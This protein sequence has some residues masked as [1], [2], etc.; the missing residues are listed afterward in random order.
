MASKR[1]YYEILGVPKGA[2]DDELKKAYRKLAKKYHPDVNKENPKEAEDK[3]KEVNEAYEI[4]SDSQKRAQYDQ[5]GHAGVDPNGFGAGGFEGFGDINFGDIGDIFDTFFGFGG[6]SRKKSGPQ[7]GT[8]ILYHQEISFE[9]AAFGVEKNITINRLETCSSCKGTGAKYGTNPVTC[10]ACGGTGQVQYK[11]T[12]PFGQ[13]IKT[14]TCNKCGGEGK[15][16]SHPCETCRG[17]GLYRKNIKLEIKIPAGIDNGQRVINPGLGDFG[18]KGGPPGDLYIEVK[19][20]PH[21][22]FKREGFNVICEIPITF[23]HAALGGEIDIPTLEGKIRK[24]IPEGTQSGTIFTLKGKGIPHTRGQ[25]RGDQFF[26]V[27]VEVPKRL[28]ERQKELLVKFAEASGDEIY[29][30]RKNFF[31]K[32]KDVLGI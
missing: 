6:N 1:D 17:K 10:N 16:I 22:L 11:R 21:P 30:Q 4:L 28:N 5:F 31:D 27:L 32:M 3:F 9:E 20:K 26:K 15:V 18:A 7:R 23:V 14:E 24:N 25:G 2:S 13:F 29:E 12:T 8:D 19:V